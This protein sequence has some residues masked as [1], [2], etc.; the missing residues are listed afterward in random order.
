MSIRYWY[1]IKIAGLAP[2]MLPSHLLCLFKLNKL[3]SLRH[4]ASHCYK[5]IINC[6]KLVPLAI[7]IV[8]SY[9]IKFS[10][11]LHWYLCLIDLWLAKYIFKLILRALISTSHFWSS[12]SHFLLWLRN[13]LILRPYFL[14]Q[15]A[16]L[17]VVGGDPVLR[18]LL[19]E[20][21]LFRLIELGVELQQGLNRIVLIAAFAVY[22]CAWIWLMI[23]VSFNLGLVVVRVGRYYVA[24]YLFRQWH[25]A[26][27]PQI[28]WILIVANNSGWLHYA[29]AG[30]WQIAG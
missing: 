25:I 23:I 10:N 20:Q 17:D 2:R 6:S 1:S 28:H 18:L 11:G 30:L 26:V 5:L 27:L 3:T 16:Q 21:N 24:A 19:T 13:C 14:I 29:L 8:K 22:C 7:Q 9:S 15:F 12:L 4:I